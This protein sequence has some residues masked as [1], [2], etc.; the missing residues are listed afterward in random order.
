[1]GQRR[2]VQT[3]DFTII[4]R[5]QRYLCKSRTHQQ[6]RTNLAFIFRKCQ[7]F[8]KPETTENKK[9]VLSAIENVANNCALSKKLRIYNEQKKSDNSTI[10]NDFKLARLMRQKS[11]MALNYRG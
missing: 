6:M 10:R 2:E 9:G 8:D 4:Y 7:I 3:L 5:T 1:M 11:E